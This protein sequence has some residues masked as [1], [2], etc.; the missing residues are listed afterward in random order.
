MG[1]INKQRQSG[2]AMT[3]FTLAAAFFL[4]PLF[5]LIPWLGKIIDIR[6]S[7]IQMARYEAWEYAT[8]YA[9]SSQQPEDF[10]RSQPVKSLNATKQ[11]ARQRFLSDT[12]LPF[13][14]SDRNGWNA[15]QINP[16]WH[17][18]T[19]NHLQAPMLI[20]A[21]VN[22]GAT[23]TLSGEDN[24]PDYIGLYTVIAA[25]IDFIGQVLGF[26]SDLIG[27]PGNFDP[28]NNEG[29]F[30]TTV[31]LPIVDLTD[32]TGN[33]LVVP[34]MQNI[35]MTARA[36]LLT[37]GWNAGGTNHSM[38]RAKGLVATSL[39]DNPIVGIGQDVI[40]VI[41]P[42][43]RG[44]DPLIDILPIFQPLGPPNMPVAIPFGEDPDT[45]KDVGSLWWGHVD[46]DAVNPDR[47]SLDADELNPVG[48]SACDNSTGVCQ[49]E[50]D[51]LPTRV[52]RILEPGVCY[53]G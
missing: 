53:Y 41:A 6:H 33:T 2:Q 50:G 39:L 36:A 29:L 12:S 17:D 34:Q 32:T 24:T 27:A 35:A 38:T 31:N 46:I 42:E 8:W 49:F 30:S 21:A 4:V 43:L 14:N 3:E 19:G 9:D 45:G 47:L 16:L 28:V 44:C 23:S 10:T 15:A 48:Q 22:S 26:F 25:V 37:D 13:A 40:G 1:L 5:L 11:E 20:D 7:T 51:D 52:P 18:H